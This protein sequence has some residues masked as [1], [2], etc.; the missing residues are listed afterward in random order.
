MPEDKVNQTRLTLLKKGVIGAKV[1]PLSKLEEFKQ[2][3]EVRGEKQHGPT[4]LEA[5]PQN[6]GYNYPKTREKK[7][8]RNVKKETRWVNKLVKK[9]L[10][11]NS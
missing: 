1:M 10:K 3:S 6:W 7:T 11:K 9:W 2:V 8:K 5:H 4:I